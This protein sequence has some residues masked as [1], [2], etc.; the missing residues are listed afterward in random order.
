MNFIDHVAALQIANGQI[1]LLSTPKNPS[2]TELSTFGIGQI[3]TWAVQYEA[4]KRENLNDSEYIYLNLLIQ[5]KRMQN[6]EY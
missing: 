5:E 1:F 6:K 3:K 2:A 4:S